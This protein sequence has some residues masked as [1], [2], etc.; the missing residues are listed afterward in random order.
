MS[1]KIMASVTIP[2]S[3][4]A[5]NASRGATTKVARAIAPRRSVGR[6]KELHIRRAPEPPAAAQNGGSRT[7]GAAHP[8]QTEPGPRAAVRA[9]KAPQGGPRENV[10]PE[11]SP[12]AT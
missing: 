9:P 3:G 8:R 7:G 12:Q 2:G 4:N 5:W 6:R 1:G 10:T 11:L